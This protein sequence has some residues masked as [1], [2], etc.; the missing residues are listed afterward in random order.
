LAPAHDARAGRTVAC[1]LLAGL[2][3]VL[4]VQRLVGFDG[5]I[6]PLV[7]VP[8]LLPYLTVGA[9]LPVGTSLVARR[10]LPAL[11]ALAAA[12][13]LAATVAPRAIGHHLDATPG[14]GVEVMTANL[15][16][17]HADPAAVVTLAHRVDVLALAELTEPELAALE[18][19]GL[20]KALPYAVTNASPTSTGTGL[21]S[22]YPLTDPGRQ[23]LLND[24]VETTA[25]VHIPHAEP[26][27]VTVVHYCAPVD[28]AQA[29]C[30]E[31]GWSRIPGATPGG[32]VRLLLGDFNLTLDYRA[33]R[34]VL[35]TGY[36]DAA[37]VVGQGL[38]TTWP[39]DGTPLPK[40]AIDHVLADRRIGVRAVSPYH[41]KGSDHRALAAAL[42]LPQSHSQ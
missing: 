25:T 33:L 20:E 15:N 22:R 1:W 39:Y 23:R 19:A 16:E 14:T 21:F 35:D 40:V 37:A 3:A 28:P 31:Y 6:W 8:A 29:A 24:Y 13:T 10:W 34:A 9:L 36:R 41:L 5:G 27:T 4:A 2:W 17:G 38:A 7:L 12:A 32:P 30:W 42:T 26:V 11:L 18:N